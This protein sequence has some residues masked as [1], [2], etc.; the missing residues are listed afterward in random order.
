M[1]KHGSYKIEKN[2]SKRKN[3]NR[4]HVLIPKRREVQQIPETAL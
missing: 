1:G 2:L 3:Y 4:S